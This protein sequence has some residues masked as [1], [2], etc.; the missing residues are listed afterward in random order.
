VRNLTT[1]SARRFGDGGRA[2]KEG[3]RGEVAEVVARGGGGGGEGR[4]RGAVAGPVARTVALVAARGRRRRH[5]VERSEATGARSR[6]G[7]DEW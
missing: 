3:Q 1:A 6:E 7:D 4:H 2:N 5:H